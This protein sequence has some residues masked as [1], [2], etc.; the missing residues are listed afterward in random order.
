M[1]FSDFQNEQLDV[2][3]LSSLKGGLCQVPPSVGCES[4][5]CESA[6]ESIADGMCTTAACSSRAA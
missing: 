4:H 5:V 1:K 2:A 3:L 6:A